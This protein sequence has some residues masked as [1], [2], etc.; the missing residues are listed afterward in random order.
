MGIKGVMSMADYDWVSIVSLLILFTTFVAI[1]IW[2]LTRPK[3]VMDHT[4]RIPLDDTIPPD[5][6][7]LTRTNKASKSLK[8]GDVKA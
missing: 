2:T 3:H 8:N 6:Q 4:A 1:V 5:D 7:Q